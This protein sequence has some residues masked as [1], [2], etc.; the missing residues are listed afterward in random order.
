MMNDLR[1]KN[2]KKG[3]IESKVM[4]SYDLDLFHFLKANLKDLT[5]FTRMRITN[6]LTNIL[7]RKKNFNR[8]D[9]FSL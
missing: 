5:D 7:K 9:V 8:K 1:K 4:K 6:E 3:R 2:K